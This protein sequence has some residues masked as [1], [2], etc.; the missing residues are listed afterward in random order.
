MLDSADHGNA[1]AADAAGQGTV[2]ITKVAAG[3]A[4]YARIKRDG[5]II[6]WSLRHETFWLRQ[7]ADVRRPA[8]WAEQTLSRRLP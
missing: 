3:P 5:R 2:I 6:G 1:M 8:L 4:N 7:A